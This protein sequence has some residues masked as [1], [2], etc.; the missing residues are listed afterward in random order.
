MFF[1]LSKIFWMVATPVTLLVVIALLGV[2]FAHTRLGRASQAVAAAALLALLALIVTPVGYLLLWPLENRFP[3]PPADMP[4]PYG[5]IILGGALNGGMSTAHNQPVFDEGER[6]V[7]AA[8]L[9]KRY[10]SA[11]I[12]FS[13]G[14][15][16]L[17]ASSSTEAD[18]ARKLLIGLGVDPARITLED[19]SRNTDENARF[20]AA[21]VHPEPSQRWLL[22]TSAFHMPRSMGLYEKAGFNVTPYPVA[23][24]TYGPGSTPPWNFDPARN[25][26]QVEF[27]VKEWIGLAVYR[28]TGKIDTLFPGPG[29]AR[30]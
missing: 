11:K 12:L 14:N 9:A 29:D 7:V 4:A 21:L 19:Q 2:L 28:A 22:V 13:G 3:Q 8:L 20:S 15:G 5:I 24:R 10:P 30:R 27:A 26:Q 23:F 18:E 17:L 16:S 25:L 6:V 1:T